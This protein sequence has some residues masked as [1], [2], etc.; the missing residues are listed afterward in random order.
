MKSSL[1]D[2][3]ICQSNLC[4]DTL[5]CVFLPAGVEGIE[6]RVRWGSQQRPQSILSKCRL[7]LFDMDGYSSRIPTSKFEA[8]RIT[9]MIRK[10]Y[11]IFRTGHLNIGVGD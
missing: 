8:M 1:S 7:A 5:V 3:P 2:N 10:V 11:L 6:C 9:I 4:V